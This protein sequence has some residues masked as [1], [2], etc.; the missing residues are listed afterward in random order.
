MGDLGR[1]AV[2]EETAT[3]RDGDG[4]VGF[5]VVSGFV[6]FWGWGVGRVK[7]ES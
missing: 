6:G 4:A 3:D 2:G 7:A 5:W 1:E